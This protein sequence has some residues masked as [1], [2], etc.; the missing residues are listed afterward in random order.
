MNQYT[1]SLSRAHVIADRL[2][3]LAEAKR[4]EAQQAFTGLHLANEL[5]EEQS[6]ALTGRGARAK[7]FLQEAREAFGLVAAIR[8]QVA[9]ANAQ[10]GISRLL[11]ETE[12]KRAEIRLLKEATAQDMLTATSVQGVNAALKARPTDI[13]GR[14]LGTILVSL[15]SLTDLDAYRTELAVLQAQ[16]NALS[17]QVNDL[18]KHTICVELPTAFAKE[19]GL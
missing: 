15:I 9:E 12:A 7:R 19:V 2:R 8:A 13:H 18:N 3:K 5:T 14:Q 1:L 16:V 11:A 10:H 6:Q 17:D 4:L